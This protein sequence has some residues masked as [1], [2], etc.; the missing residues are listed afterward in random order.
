MQ[1]P[2]PSQQIDLSQRFTEYLPT[3]FGGAVVF[4]LGVAAGWVAKRAVVRV[5]IWLRL[6]RLGGR[7][8]WRAAFGKGDVRAALYEVSGTIVMALV[9]LV[10]LE[11]ALKLWQ[12]VGMAE[13]TE[14][15]ILYVP[16]LAVVGLIVGIGWWLAGTFAR[17]VEEALEDEGVAKAPLLAKGLKAALLAVVV[18]VALW[19]LNL[20]REIVLAAF[21]IAFGAMGIAFAVAV[22]LGSAKAVQRGLETLFGPG[23][24][25]R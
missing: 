12:L 2:D 18:A 17:R 13:L 9:V 14:R 7:Y 15:I 10:F 3:L 25:N 16:N 22:G 8:G 4:A 6:D 23:K 19:Q 20:A 1:T 24:E 21:L 5:L 11:E